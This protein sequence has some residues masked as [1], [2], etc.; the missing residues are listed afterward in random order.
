MEVSSRIRRHIRGRGGSSPLDG[1]YELWGGGPGWSLI[2]EVGTQ[3]R[4]RA[5]T[6]GI[7]AYVSF[8]ERSDGCW[9]YVVGRMSPFVPFDVPAL[10]GSLN[11]A[12][13]A[14]KDCWGG[15]NL[16]GVSPRIRGSRLP[17]DAVE[18]L[19]NKGLR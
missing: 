4:I 2:R 11:E 6:D 10:L 7:R 17:P 9:C 19:I 12:E 18:G 1:R 16:V 8:R 5:T 13:E 3:A 15:N 14:V